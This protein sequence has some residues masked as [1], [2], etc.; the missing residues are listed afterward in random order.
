[1]KYSISEL[2]K[3]VLYVIYA[4]IVLPN[5]RLI[6]YPIDIRGKKNIQF[7]KGL[8]TGYHCRIETHSVNKEKV[9]TIGENVQF[10]DFVHIAAKQSVIIGD[11]VLIASKVFISDISHGFYKGNDLDSDPKVDPKKR[12]LTSSPVVISE[13]VWIGESAS[14]LAGVRIGKASVIGANSVVTKDIPDYSIA[15]GNP[16][17][18]IKKYNFNT[19]H[20]EKLD[21]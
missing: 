21:S 10:N 15:V 4:K 17:K 13:N 2:L 5:S 19:K 16:A 7:G 11:N 20:W 18:V 6:R 14:I 12:E 9:L 1:M 8:T 3:L